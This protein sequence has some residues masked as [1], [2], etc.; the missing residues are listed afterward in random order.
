[1]PVA[2]GLIHLCGADAGAVN[3]LFKQMRLTGHTCP[4]QSAHQHQR[5]LHR[6]GSVLH[7]GPHEH[8]R[9]LRRDLILQTECLLC[10]RVGAA[11]QLHKAAAVGILPCRDHR[12][13]Q[14]HRIG[15]GLGALPGNVQHGTGKCQMSA[16]RKAAYCDLFRQ[17]M[18]PGRVLPHKAD[19]L[20]QL[21]QRQTVLR[22]FAD[23][24]VQHS[25]MISRCCKL[26]CHRVALP[27]ADV[28]I[29]AAGHHQHQRPVDGLRHPFAGIPQIN[30]QRSAAFQFQLLQLH[31][32]FPLR[33]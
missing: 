27:G 7:G 15:P 22:L 4:V 5:I 12:I 33:K 28:G 29:A 30:S 6:N 21:A 11:R 1:M 14:D 8:R 26:Q 19:G 13:A 32:I 9:R 16:R 31:D 25:G 17:D 18:P 24:V 2:A 10:R 3:P 20:C 23:G